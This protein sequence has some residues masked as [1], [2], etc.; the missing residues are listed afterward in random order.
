MPASGV[1]RVVKEHDKK[2]P[3][4]V[5]ERLTLLGGRNLYGEPRFRLSW[6]NARLGWRLSRVVQRG[7]KGSIPRSVVEWRLVP[8][9]PF[10]KDRFVVEVYHPA[11][12]Y[13]S[14]EAWKEARTKVVKGVALFP[15]GPYPSRGDYELFDVLYAEEGPAPGSSLV[16]DVAKASPLGTTR[17]RYLAP[18][19]AYVEGL[20]ARY[21]YFE[22]LGEGKRNA[23]LDED[24]AKREKEQ[25]QT[26]YEAAMAR[27]G[28]FSY[29]PFVAVDGL[30]GKEAA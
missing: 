13:G 19:I 18:S 26:Y 24:E 16:S 1:I 2:V 4:E 29:D 22:W 21:W 17:H 7:E 8:K 9:Y 30:K 28:A 27:A 20:M 5:Q 3:E 11:E 10:A 12:W 23:S 14:P 25:F 15:E 6:A